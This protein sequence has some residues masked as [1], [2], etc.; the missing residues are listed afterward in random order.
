MDDFVA[1]TDV[2]EENMVVSMFAN[3]M[4]VKKTITRIAS[5]DLRGMLSELGMNNNVSQKN[6]VANKI[7]SYIRALSNVR[8]SNLLTLSLLVNGQ[9]E[10]LE[11][12]ANT[13][14]DVYDKP[15]KELKI[16]R[17]CLIACI[18]RDNQVM[19]PDGNSTITKGDTVVV[20]TTHKNFDDFSDIFA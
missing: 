9:V 7:V 16:K 19:I 13:K 14:L 10:A 5:D 17:N 6:V 3:K 2:E 4:N 8:G 18:I 20:V 11:F 12:L 15:L 1:L